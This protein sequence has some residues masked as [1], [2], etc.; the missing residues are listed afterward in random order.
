MILDARAANSSR[1]TGSNSSGRQ[2][3]EDYRDSASSSRQFQEA[4]ND[5]DSSRCQFFEVVNPTARGTDN[6]RVI[7]FRQLGARIPRALYDSDSS[8]RLLLEDCNYPSSSGRHFLEEYNDSS[9]SGRQFLTDYNDSESSGWH[10]L[11]D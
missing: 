11:K 7:Q 5:S 1:T 2:L 3:L 6:S 9:R 8:G 10:F 4:Y